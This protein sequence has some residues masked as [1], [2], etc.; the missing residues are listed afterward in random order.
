MW[1]YQYNHS[2]MLVDWR[3]KLSSRTL[4]HILQ[5]HKYYKVCSPCWAPAFPEMIVL[6][7][8]IHVHPEMSALRATV[9]IFIE[10]D[11]IRK[12]LVKE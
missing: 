3:E 12:Q 1:T 7:I 6:Q 9:A 5:I 11:S 8:Y 4:K 2:V 10:L